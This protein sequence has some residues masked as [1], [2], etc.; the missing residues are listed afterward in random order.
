MFCWNPDK[1]IKKFGDQWWDGYSEDAWW[2]RITQGRTPF[3]SNLSQTSDILYPALR[4][5]HLCIVYSLFSRQEL[6]QLTIQE[7]VTFWMAW[8]S[9]PLEPNM[10]FN[11]GA[12]L[13]ERMYSLKLG[14]THSEDIKCGRMITWITYRLG[15]GHELNLESVDPFLYLHFQALR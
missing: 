11:H 6:G 13:V 9:E 3:L 2:R 1:G 12:L 14:K 5:F 10:L 4:Y 8:K 7:V 15:L